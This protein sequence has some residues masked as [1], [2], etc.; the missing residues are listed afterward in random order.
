M[1]RQKKAAEDRRTPKRWRAERSARRTRSVWECASPLALWGA[2]GNW[3][4]PGKGEI[5]VEPPA[6]MFS[7]SVRSDICFYAAPDGA[8]EVFG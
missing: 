2:A 6:I 3:P 7:S 4:S 8:F 5:F 1:I